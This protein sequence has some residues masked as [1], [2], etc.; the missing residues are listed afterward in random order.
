MKGGRLRLVALPASAGVLALGAL[1]WFTAIGQAKP[2]AT[3]VSATLVDAKDHTVPVASPPPAG[4]PQEAAPGSF[5]AIKVTATLASGETWRSTSY[6]FGGGSAT[7]DN[8]ANRNDAGTVTEYVEATLPE[9][10]PTPGSVTVRLYA[11]DGCTG[12]PRASAAS[13]F[14]IRA[15]TENQVL[16]PHCDTRVALV[17]DESGSIGSTN[18]AQQAVIN[19]SK[20][21]VNGLV[22][23]GAQLP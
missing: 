22:D 10:T 16:A 20:A 21:F 11:A 1:L 4:S 14:T 6:A 19:G 17:L 2:T 18:G 9:T 15:R 7:C 23:S 5:V 8:D 3:N 12:T 13:T